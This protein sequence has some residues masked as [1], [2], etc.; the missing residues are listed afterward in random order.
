MFLSVSVT[1]VLA[2]K[3]MPEHKGVVSG[4]TQGFSWGIAAILIAPLGVLAQNVS[5]ESAIY[6]T[7]II[8]F[9]TGI[10][11]VSKDLEY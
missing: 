8:S 2:Q 10:F 3:F 1:V 7:S 5:I 9:I 4:V 6:L 11:F